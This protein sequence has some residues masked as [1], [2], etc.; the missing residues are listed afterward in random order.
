REAADRARSPS[1][2]DFRYQ[3][4]SAAC[5]PEGIDDEPTKTVNGHENRHATVEHAPTCG[6]PVFV[7]QLDIG[8]G[9]GCLV[10][11]YCSFAYSALACFRMGTSGSASFH[12]VRK[13][14]YA[15]RA[16]TGSPVSVKARPSPSFASVQY[17]HGPRAPR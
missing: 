7:S 8:T 4:R 17:G 3:N 2:A 12:I 1:S 9:S 6:V 10:F 11:S 14:W 16:L 15:V 13:S 5:G